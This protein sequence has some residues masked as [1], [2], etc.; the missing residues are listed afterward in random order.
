MPEEDENVKQEQVEQPEE[1]K[2]RKRQVDMETSSVD[3]GKVIYDVR[4]L[5]NKKTKFF[6]P[7]YCQSFLQKQQE[8]K[9][10]SEWMKQSIS[11]YH[12]QDGT[13][14][15]LQKDNRPSHSAPFPAYQTH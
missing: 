13:Q 4:Q 12:S 7:S 1:T 15:W 14:Q 6:E 5:E 3:S 11:G 9:H 8:S 10:S 2:D